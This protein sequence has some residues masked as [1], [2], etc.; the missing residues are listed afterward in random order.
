MSIRKGNIIIIAEEPDGICELCGKKDETRPYGPNGA[1]ICY[2]CGMKDE[3]A[4]NERMGRI[5]FGD[6]PKH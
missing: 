4:T 3:K 5:L 2:E 6:E 1:R